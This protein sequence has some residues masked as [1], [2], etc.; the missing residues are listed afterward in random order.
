MVKLPS[1]IR[2]LRENLIL[3][4]L[5]IIQKLWKDKIIPEV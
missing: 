2:D 3:K 1:G 5:Q 4:Q